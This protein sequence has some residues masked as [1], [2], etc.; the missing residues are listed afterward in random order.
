MRLH[1][2]YPTF[3]QTNNRVGKSIFFVHQLREYLEFPQGDLQRFPVP[4]TKMTRAANAIGMAAVLIRVRKDA[5]T[6]VHPETKYPRVHPRANP[7]SRC[8]RACLPKEGPNALAR[9]NKGSAEAFTPR[10]ACIDGREGRVS[11]MD[12]LAA[13]VMND[14]RTRELFFCHSLF[15]LGAAEGSAS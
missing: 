12:G 1:F 6:F 3:L 11:Y 8:S 4:R 2:D 9:V 5:S 14:V 10:L 7:R 15:I 13:P